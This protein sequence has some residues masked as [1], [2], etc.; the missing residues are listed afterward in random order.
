MHCFLVSIIYNLL[1]IYC[2][3]TTNTLWSEVQ[4][5]PAV[6]HVAYW[7]ST[8]SVIEERSHL[9][10][11][12]SCLSHERKLRLICRTPSIT[13]F[14]AGGDTEVSRWCERPNSLI[15][16][17]IC[18]FQVRKLSLSNFVETGVVI[19]ITRSFKIG[20]G[21][22][23]C[24]VGE[25]RFI[26]E[27]HARRLLVAMISRKNFFGQVKWLWYHKRSE[28]IQRSCVLQTTERQRVIE[29]D[30]HGF[31]VTII[32]NSLFIDTVQ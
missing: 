28:N 25:L 12:W 13:R 4:S 19:C 11:I 15:I 9:S 1:F 17:S 5:W 22:V 30:L 26:F 21:G 14:L 10:K 29:I 3:V 6:W 8:G 27:K 24:E 18:D 20:E 2:T 7:E 31:L 32:D 16:G 23:G